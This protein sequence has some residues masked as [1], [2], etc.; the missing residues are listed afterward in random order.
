MIFLSCRSDVHSLVVQ[1]AIILRGESAQLQVRVL[2][3]RKRER[4]GD[5]NL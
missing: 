2:T 5:Y 4:N 3:G 1:R